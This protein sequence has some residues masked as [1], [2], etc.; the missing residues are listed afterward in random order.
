MKK[1][2]LNKDWL[3]NEQNEF[4]GVNLGSDFCTEH[5][6]GINYIKAAFAIDGIVKVKTSKLFGIPIRTKIEPNFGIIGRVINEVPEKFVHGIAGK[7][8]FIGFYDSL[9]AKWMDSIVKEA[10]TD[11]NRHS[12]PFMAYWCDRGFLLVSS[13]QEK[14]IQLRDSILA[15][16]LAIYLGGR[17]FISNNGL[18]LSIATKLDKPVIDAMEQGDRSVYELRKKAD[19]TG[20]YDRIRESDKRYFALTPK[21]KD[22]DNGLI[23]FWLNPENQR[24]YNSGHFTVEELDQ[25]I[26]NE[27]PI[28][29]QHE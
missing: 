9:S 14:I 13:D 12:S 21:W 24:T 6:C 29:K 4:C 17:K 23:H 25:W 10:I 3:F 28:I 2:V 19:A 11:N 18:V 5:E 16:N 15:L 7:Y 8:R 22:K 1:T 26:A 27:G 20:I